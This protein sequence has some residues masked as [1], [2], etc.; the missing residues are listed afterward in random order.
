[1]I[2]DSVRRIVL[3]ELADGLPAVTPEFGS[4][5]AQAAAICFDEQE[6]TNGVVV[7]EFSRPVSQ[8]ERR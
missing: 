7:V 5:I 4:A 1:L 6:H 3:T 2:G 8:V